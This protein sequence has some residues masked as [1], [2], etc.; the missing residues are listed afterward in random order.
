M[1]STVRIDGSLGEGGGQVVRTSLALSMITQRPFV[2]ENV[3]AGRK[4]PGLK[5]QHLTAVRA[6]ATISNAKVEGDELSSSYLAFEPGPVQNGEYYFSIGTA[7]SATLV[8]QTVLPAL[9]LSDLPSK[10]TLEG[11]TH[12][13]WAP[14]FDFLQRAFIPVL[15]RFGPRIL[16]TLHQ[17]GFYPSGGGKFTAE[18]IPSKNL[19]P[20][21]LLERGELI[22]KDVTALVANLPA[23]IAR[24][25]VETALRSLRWPS[26]SGQYR[27][28]VANGPG[29]VV[30]I[31]I[32]Y[33]NVCEVF[34][35]CGR[36]GVPAEK[37]AKEAVREAKSYLACSAAVGPHMADQLLLPLALSA[38]QGKGGQFST[39]ELTQHSL[40]Q[41]EII[42]KFLD[43]DIEVKNRDE[44]P[45][46]LVSV[47]PISS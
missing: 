45:V 38:A 24:R 47:S 2:I 43:I 13:Q 35:A 42:R 7:G 44:E 14:P 15:E 28:V 22:K 40:T 23:S 5:R 6:A 36:L 33:Q 29:N 46:V 31:V 9:M 39:L 26:Q 17:P 21:E 25:E 3:R 34:T 18:I 30:L 27:E 8:L 12:N 1:S 10:V 16:L 37:V 32:E 20:L 41:I 4:K 19:R 11:G